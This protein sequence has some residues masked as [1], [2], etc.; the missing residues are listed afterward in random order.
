MPVIPAMLTMI[1]VEQAR[2]YSDAVKAEF[3]RA[4][5]MP[6]VGELEIEGMDD[7]IRRLEN[8]DIACAT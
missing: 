8:R 1:L 7:Q 5:G 3:E 2:T 4:Q 6:Y